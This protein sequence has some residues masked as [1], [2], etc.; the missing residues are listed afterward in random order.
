MIPLAVVLQPVF[1]KP[2]RPSVAKRTQQVEFPATEQVA[3]V[4]AAAPLCAVVSASNVRE[5]ATKRADEGG[6][7]W[8]QA[9]PMGS[10]CE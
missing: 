9:T 4:R 8:P 3:T 6:M 7:C 1:S 2:M 10:G 5:I